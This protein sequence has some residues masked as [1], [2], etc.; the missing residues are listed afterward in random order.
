MSSIPAW[1]SPNPETF[2][3]Y[4]LTYR[5]GDIVS[6]HVAVSEPL[7]LELSDFRDAILTGTDAAV[8]SRARSRRRPD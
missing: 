6:P 2:G 1:S 4:K 7:F 8:V 3:E 5:T